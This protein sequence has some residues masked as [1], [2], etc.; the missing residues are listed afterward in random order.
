MATHRG[1]RQDSSQGV[2]SIDNAPSKTRIGAPLRKITL[3][4]IFGVFLLAGVVASL[5]GMVNLT[6]AGLEADA[7]GRSAVIPPYA[8]QSVLA[9]PLVCVASI[10]A[11][12]VLALRMRAAKP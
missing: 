5:Y 10:I 6:Y 8:W 4:V 3:L 1:V 2:Q 12:I 7:T 11:I 9:G